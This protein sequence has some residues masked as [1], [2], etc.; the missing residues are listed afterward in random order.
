MAAL[1]DPT[2]DRMSEARARASRVRFMLFDIDGVFTDG[3]LLFGPDGEQLKGQRM[4]FYDIKPGSL[5]W[6][7]EGSND[8]G[9]TW[10]L[11]W[12]LHYTKASTKP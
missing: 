11:L 6:D 8:G 10:R 3:Q 9:K 1:S 5:S 7:W 12:R 2:S 4:R